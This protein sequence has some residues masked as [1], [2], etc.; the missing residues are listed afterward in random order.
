MSSIGVRLN[1]TLDS[2]YLGALTDI[3]S[4]LLRDAPV[5]QVCEAIFTKLRSVLQLDA[6]FHFRVT[7]DG[8]RM[9][10]ASCRGCPPER[11]PDIEFLEFG[12]AVCGTVAARREQMYVPRV[13]ECRNELT[14]FI[15]SIGIT[16]YA[17]QPLI[18]NGRLLGTFSFGMKSRHEY[19]EPELQLIELVCQQVAIATSREVA[20]EQQVEL[21][22][23]A[24]AGYMAAKIAHE[25]NNPL[26]AATN[27]LYL[28]GQTPMAGE[29][30]ELLK[31]AQE[32]LDRVATVAKQT[33][34][35]YRDCRPLSAVDL[36]HA[37]DVAVSSSI[38]AAQHKNLEIKIDAPRRWKVQAHDCELVQILTNLLANAIHHSPEG[39][40]VRVSAIS[41]NS[42]V[43][44][45]VSDK[46]PGI[47]PEHRSKIFE[48]FF[49]TNKQTGN[50]LG[51]WISKELAQRMDALLLLAPSNEGA[52]FELRL[53]AAS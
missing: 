8:T 5:D 30:R 51:L 23:L 53:R 2:R 43:N 49:T 18:V 16:C 45:F 21:E 37:I 1:K 17:C 25:I 22:R 12:Q 44:V 33:L 38:F 32:Q 4:L 3:T 50:G 15:H 48:P 11:L 34:S 39:E 42:H 40:S 36:R 31:K 7:S 27:L 24:G 13:L 46:G 6:Y 35:Y 10:L 26:A 29:G 47:S 28:M 9:R 14:E 19:S 52:T 20:R 41:R